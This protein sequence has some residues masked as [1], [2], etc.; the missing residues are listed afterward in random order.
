MHAERFDG[1]KASCEVRFV[2]LF[3][4]KIV[5]TYDSVKDQIIFK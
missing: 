1:A 2:N 4:F 3:T 5:A